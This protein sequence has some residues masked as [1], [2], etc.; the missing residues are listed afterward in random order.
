MLFKVG[1]PWFKSGIPLSLQLR[2]S[3]ALP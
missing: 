2:T 3:T 1:L